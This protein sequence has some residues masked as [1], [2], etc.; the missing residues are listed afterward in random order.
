MPNSTKMQLLQSNQIL[1]VYDRLSDLAWYSTRAVDLW[2]QDFI[3]VFTQ[4]DGIVG[5]FHL[6]NNKNYV[7]F[8]FAASCVVE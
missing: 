2:Y 1:F 5:P 6:I 3:V 4:T 8:V 7:V